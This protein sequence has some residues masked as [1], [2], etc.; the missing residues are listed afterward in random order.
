MELG[1]DPSELLNALDDASCFEAAVPDRRVGVGF[2][3]WGPA[4]SPP[5]SRMDWSLRHVRQSDNVN[6][7]ESAPSTGACPTLSNTSF[8]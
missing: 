1:N 3:C 2:D 8:C 4:A 5:S 6:L 7:A